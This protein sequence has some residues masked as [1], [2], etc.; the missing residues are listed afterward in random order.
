MLAIFEQVAKH[1]NAELAQKTDKHFTKGKFMFGTFFSCFWPVCCM[2]LWE[3]WILSVQHLCC[4]WCHKHPCCSTCTQ[5]IAD[6]CATHC[7]KWSV[8]QKTDSEALTC[9][10]S[11]PLGQDKGRLFAGLSRIDP[12][13]I[14][15]WNTTQ[16]QCSWFYCNVILKD[17]KCN[18]RPP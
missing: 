17:W 5:Q 3:I 12:V 11:L 15:I 18:L 1:E 16:S 8:T 9:G 10:P 2:F 13:V 4:H 14:C 7:C 6:I